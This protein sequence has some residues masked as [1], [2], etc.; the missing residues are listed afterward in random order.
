MR[1]VKPAHRTNRRTGRSTSRPLRMHLPETTIVLVTG[2][3]PDGDAIARPATWERDNGPPPTIFMAA[4]PRGRPALAPGE[5]VLA[6]LKPIGA[7]R[8]EGRTIRRLADTPGRVLG[9]FRQSRIIPTDRRAKAEWT[10]PQGHANGALDGEIVLAEPL[11]HHPPGRVSH[12]PAGMRLGL[13]PARG[14][15]RLGARGDARAGRRDGLR[16]PDVPQ[17][18]PAR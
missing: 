4:E 15:E 5:R 11:P 3:D 14:I 2:T 10:V 8:Y 7:G 6:R 12:A 17:Q 1:S 18:V 9:V 16:T 13:R